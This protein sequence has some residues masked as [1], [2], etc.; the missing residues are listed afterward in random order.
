MQNLSQ[1]IQQD[2]LKKFKVHTP[3]TLFEPN[4][5]KLQ[6]NLCP[7]CGRKLYLNR[8]KT[9]FRCKSKINDKFVITSRRLLE[10]GGSL[11]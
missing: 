11:K 5:E 6:K 1:L 2:F 8:Q 3:I 10:L 9:I 4:F 7:I